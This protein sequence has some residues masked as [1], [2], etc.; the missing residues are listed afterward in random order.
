M[1]YIKYS[2]WAV[3]A[4]C[5]I[6]VGIANRDVV[7][8]RALPDGVADLVGLSP[9]IDLPL[10]VVIFIGVA[11]GLLIGF[12]WEWIRE[13]KLRSEAGRSRREA[14]ALEQEVIRLKAE[15][16]EGKDDVLALLD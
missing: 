4:I 2:F 10:F 12:V 7:S 6:V 16:N 14:K 8:L 13:F 9:T 11:A 5:L 3:V 1:R 15:K